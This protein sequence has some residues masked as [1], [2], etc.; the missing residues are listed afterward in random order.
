LVQDAPKHP[1]VIIKWSLLVFVFFL[2]DIFLIGGETF[3]DLQDQCEE[4]IQFVAKKIDPEDEEEE[5]E[6]EDAK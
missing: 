1:Y 4:P 3:Q 6:L 2:S 5:E